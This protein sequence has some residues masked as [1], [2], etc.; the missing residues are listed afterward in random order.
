VVKLTVQE[1]KDAIKQALM[2][3][4]SP[5]R[6]RLSQLGE[7][8]RRQWFEVNEPATD[9]KGEPDWMEL[10]HF[11]KGRV[12]EDWL[13]SLFPQAIRQYEVSLQGIKGHIDLFLPPDTVLE[14]KTTTTQSLAFVPSYDHIAQTKAYLAALRFMG[15]P[16]PKGYLIY[17]L[18]DSPAQ[19]LDHIYPITLSDDEYETLCQRA[20]TLVEAETEPPPIPAHYS[21]NKL[22]CSGIVFNAPYRCPYFERCWGETG[23]IVPR[24]WVDGLG[25]Q[26][27][28]LDE[29]MARFE[30]VVKA[31]E[32]IEKKIKDVMREKG[33][34]ELVIRGDQFEIVAQMADKPR[35]YLDIKALK[36]DFGDAIRRYLKETYPIFVRWRKRTG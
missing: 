30:Q 36:E 5:S 17:I 13:A 20:K 3:E 1:I 31:R 18:A 10:G 21:P 11:L 16:D 35:E 4:P 32:E 19:A 24:S 28:A 26:L 9:E 23:A 14:A 8:L 33:L 2:T 27:V 12:F 22:P 6:Y 34:R 25:A 15:V 29:T 7:C